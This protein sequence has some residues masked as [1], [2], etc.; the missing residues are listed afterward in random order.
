MPSTLQQRFDAIAGAAISGNAPT[1]YPP[2][3]HYPPPPTPARLRVMTS[4]QLVALLLD[5]DHRRTERLGP[6][7]QRVVEYASG[8]CVKHGLRYQRR[9]HRG[10][11]VFHVQ[12]GGR[13][14]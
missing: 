13:I 10:S 5:A 1:A 7:R 2:P 9:R 11:C 6:G 4:L 14:A 8:E 3:T 12:Y